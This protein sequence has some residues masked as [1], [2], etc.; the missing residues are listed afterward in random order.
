VSGDG[1]KHMDPAMPRLCC[2]C[3]KKVVLNGPEAVWFAVSRLEVYH[4]DCR[5][6]VAA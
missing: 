3:G 4:W 2:G 6:K 5:P 1:W